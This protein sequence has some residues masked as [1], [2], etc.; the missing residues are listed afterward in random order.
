MRRGAQSQR[1]RRLVQES[2]IALGFLL[3]AVAM[4]WPMALHLST[5]VVD[6]GDPLFTSWSLP[7]NVHALLHHP[8]SLFQANIF[9]PE[10]N[11]LAYADHMLGLVPVAAPIWLLSHNGVLTNNATSLLLVALAGW[12]A[13]LL[14]FEVARSRAA[15]VVAGV[16][17]AFAPFHMAHI[18][19]TNLL[20][21]YPMVLALLFALRTVR[22]ARI[23]DA[24]GLAVFWT[25]AML[26]S[27]YYLVFC[28]VAVAV[29]AGLELWRRRRSPSTYRA[30]LRLVGAGAVVAAF[31]LAFAEPYFAVRRDH[32]EAT[33]PLAEAEAYTPGPS[34]FVWAP[35]GNRIYGRLTAGL[36]PGGGA[37]EKVLFPGIA[38]VVLAGAGV[39]RAIRRRRRD[40][41]TPWLVLMA[42]M[43]AVAAG[44]YQTIFGR[45]NV[46]MPFY[47][48]YSSFEFL[49]FMRSMA[50]SDVLV[51]L[52]LAVLAS[53]GLAG[54]RPRRDRVL[55]CSLAAMIVAA[56]FVST[57]MPS[58]AVPRVTAA[59]DWLAGSRTPGAV[60]ELPT[61]TIKGGQIDGDALVHEARYM[62]LSTRH[63][64]PLLNGYSGFMPPSYR[65]MVEA[66]ADFPSASS[67]RFLRSLRVAFVIVHIGQVAGTP[68]ARMYF[69]SSVPGGLREEVDDGRVRIYRVL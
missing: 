43:L 58:F 55:I 67:L 24:A 59:Y 41:T 13:Y 20:S 45:R 14:S 6:P 64:R 22:R 34:S 12:S 51:M 8:F 60:L 40:Q 29:I 17:F 9:W 4:T 56:E 66:V 53:I 31:G 19:H 1:R 2:V 36:R 50:R 68:W 32:P 47:Y 42:A 5:R 37:N 15:G 27:W 26:S 65:Q 35:E 48:L 33:R 23:V 57:P 11:T 38:T 7:W 39:A 21:T 61:A 28:S 44:P 54:V 62:S 46:Q 18:G 49:R 25:L 30:V 16:I 10:P 63:W 3:A 52:S 69:R